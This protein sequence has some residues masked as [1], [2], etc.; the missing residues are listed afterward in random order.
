MNFLHMLQ[1]D[2]VEFLP[3]RKFMGK[4]QGCAR[5]FST[6]YYENTVVAEFKQQLCKK[7][8]VASD[9]HI[10]FVLK[11]TENSQV[12]VVFSDWT[13]SIYVK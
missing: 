6:P 12:I 2:L 7:F 5:I 13:M 1:L 3:Y 4:L 9:N 10:G 11:V 8:D